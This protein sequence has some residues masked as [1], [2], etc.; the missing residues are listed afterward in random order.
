MNASV[1]IPHCDIPNNASSAQTVPR[2]LLV[3]LRVYLGVI[4][5]I[6]QSWQADTRQPILDGNARLSSR[7]RHAPRVRTLSPLHPTGGRSALYL[8][9]LPRD[10]QRSG[11]SAFASHEDD[12]ARWRRSRNVSIP[13]LHVGGGPDALVAGQ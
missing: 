6:H 13:Q 4:L 7:R 11:R 2:A 1:A 8:I 5:F 9:Q 12:D 10:D 3:T